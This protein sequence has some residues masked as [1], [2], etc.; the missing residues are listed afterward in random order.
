MSYLFIKNKFQRKK[1]VLF[2]KKLK[3]QKKQ[4]NPKNIF[5]GF[6]RWGFFGGG[7]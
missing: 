5:S 6:F 3:I 4:K 7:F 2:S 1:I